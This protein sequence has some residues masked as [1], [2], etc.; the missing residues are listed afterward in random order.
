[1]RS[2]G[3]IIAAAVAVSAQSLPVKKVTLYKSGVGSFERT[4]DVP[5]GSPVQLEFKTDQMDDVLKSLTLQAGS[6]LSVKGVRYDLNIPLAERLQELGI[7][8][9]PQS[10]LAVL[11]DQWRGSKLDVRYR[12]EAVSGTILSARVA[13]GA[14]GAQ[15]QELN[16]MLDSGEVRMLL[17]DEV[18]EFK[19]ADA[20]Q[21][22]KLQKAL[23]LAAQL[24]SDLKKTVTIDTAG[25]GT[26]PLLVRY[27]TAMPLW[28]SAYRLNL[29]E[30]GDPTL[31]GWAIV[32]NKTGEDWN[33]ISL[34]LVSG[35]P[36]SFISQLYEPQ[37]VNRPVAA[38]RENE[39]V[40]PDVYEG[41]VR[42]E[43]LDAGVGGGVGSGVVGVAPE[44]RSSGFKR[45]DGTRL[46][47]SA[48][49]PPPPP[50][51][52]Y[53]GNAGV[54]LQQNMG[55]AMMQV[56]IASN[57]TREAGELFEYRFDQ[58]VSAK[59]GE[60][61]L[62]PFV[63]QSVKALQVDVYSDRSTPNPR[64]AVELTNNT[65]KTLD[66]GP[67]TL[68]RAGDYAGE[69]LVETLRNGDKRLFSYAVDLGLRI[70]S[71]LDSSSQVV[72]EIHASG[73]VLTAR[74]AYEVTTTFTAHNVDARAK[75]LLIE[76]PVQSGTKILSPTPAETTSSLYR[77]SVNVP[78]KG[79]A[80]LPVKEES[81]SDATFSIGMMDEGTALFYMQNK[82]LSAQG[83]Q[84]LQQMIDKKRQ[85]ASVDA[86]LSRLDT[87]VREAN[88]E[89]QR[90]RQNVDS[91]NRVAGQ[92]EQVRK[93]AAQLTAQDTRLAQLRDQQAALRK[94]K[95]ALT[96]ELNAFVEKMEF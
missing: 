4:G 62:V 29:P 81:M 45:A 71:K 2:V 96:S 16:L 46:G 31:Q 33:N 75:T 79:D 39:A 76:H 52:K 80:T 54:T 93:Y 20:A 51:P 19:F 9:P 14:N 6:G 47:A 36:V 7:E 55:R 73:G 53:Q 43:A 50:S 5:A 83:K 91:L 77:F 35:K 66:G 59:Q 88:E 25:T 70:S 42:A 30:T 82:A 64:A 61:L 12:G 94:Q 24:K 38:L 23:Q 10:S 48:A 17:M 26:H 28:K 15:R 22:Q 84:Q 58:P 90:L 57:T 60:S 69:G 72:R 40:G 92:D 34:N 68:Y 8:L 41:D 32:E 21:Q 11:L 86:D 85:I 78:A 3:L 44:A 63:Q 13:G 89:Q 37:M 95:A 67:I 1:M 56:Q 27:L 74:S 49:P 65:G 18:T 87:E